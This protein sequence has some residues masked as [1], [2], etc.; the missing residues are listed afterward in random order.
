MS[1][2]LVTGGAG[3]V[4]ARL[5]PSL[6]DEGHH[7][8][9]FDIMFF[10]DD[11]LPGNHPNLKVIRGD[12]RNTAR[13][14]SACEVADVVLHLAAIS[15]DPSFEL[16]ESLSRTM[17][18]ECFEPLVITAKLS[19]V[20]RFIYCSTSSVYGISDSPDV[21]EDHPLVPITLYNKYKGMC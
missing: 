11:H 13:F 6:L 19:G 12:V 9:V 10:G 4:G 7:V 18:Y 8:I 15:N 20:G 1:T 2:I 3:F 14:A 5:V 21:T 17:N 16:D